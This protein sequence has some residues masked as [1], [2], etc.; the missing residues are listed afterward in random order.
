M[1]FI[2]PRVS[3]ERTLPVEGGKEAVSRDKRGRGQGSRRWEQ[4]QVRE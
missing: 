3:K 1:Y 2:L 4:S